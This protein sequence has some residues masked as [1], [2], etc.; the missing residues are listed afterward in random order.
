MPV[1]VSLFSDR[2]FPLCYCITDRQSATDTV[3][4]LLDR[5]TCSVV[6]SSTCFRE[7]S[8]GEEIRDANHL[9]METIRR[10]QQEQEGR[11]LV[12]FPTTS[13]H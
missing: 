13:R 2:E 3:F 5:G 9:R 10:Q 11:I 12:T 6:P 8:V 4:V 1:Y 7:K